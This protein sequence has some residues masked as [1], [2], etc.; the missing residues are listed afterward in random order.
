[1]NL[2]PEATES[3]QMN[4]T[5]N[6]SN[7]NAQIQNDE[8][9]S[10]LIPLLTIGAIGAIISAIIIIPNFT[11][12]RGLSTL[13]A[14]HPWLRILVLM[15]SKRTQRGQD[16]RERI[17]NSIT[18]E[19]G[20]HQRALR[21]D[22]KLSSS[23]ASI[24]LDLLVQNHSI[25]KVRDG[26]FLRY[27]PTSVKDESY[28]KTTD[29]VEPFVHLSATQRSILEVMLANSDQP[30]LIPQREIATKLDLTQAAVFQQLK[31]LKNT[32]HVRNGGPRNQFT[33]TAKGRNSL[34][35]SDNRL[36]GFKVEERT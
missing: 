19:P 26:K 12:I 3:D 29:E 8:D 13:L 25:Q 21:R 22:L 17:L 27:Y 33:L 18:S 11:L 36:G 4:D 24:H 15:P 1:M 6:A 35:S 14:R 20:R 28:K 30:K 10:T 23:Q 5:G 2:I 16:M 32:G 34:E 7:L 31:R 9:E